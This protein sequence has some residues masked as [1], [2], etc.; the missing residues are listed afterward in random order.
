MRL[1]AANERRPEEIEAV[2]A[3][4]E[5]ARPNERERMRASDR[6]WDRQRWLN[7]YAGAKANEGLRSGSER[8]IELGLLALSLHDFACDFRDDY[9]A[10]ALLFYA[11][12]RIGTDRL[13]LARRVGKLPSPRGA[14]HITDFAQR[15]DGERALSAWNLHE[16]QS[17]D[18]PLVRSVPPGWTPDQP[19]PPQD[20][21]LG[22][23]A[24]LLEK[25]GDRKK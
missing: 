22:L 21:G 3:A 7:G 18:G 5:S 23:V 20:W 13:A 6:P 4:Y 19:E 17:A 10:L 12:D 14:R 15:S 16:F 2:L 9:F 8:T 24:A 25:W 1:D 11:A